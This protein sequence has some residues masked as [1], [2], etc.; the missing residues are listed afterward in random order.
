MQYTIS[1]IIPMLNE[2]AHIGR[3]LDYLIRDNTQVNIKEIIIVDGGSDDGSREIV[4]GFPKVILLTS[5]AGRARQ[6][7][8]GARKAAGTILYFL[9]AD[10]YPPQGF[11]KK[12]IQ[13]VERGYTGC[14]RLRFDPAKHYLLR[15]GAWCTQF[16]GLWFR[17]GDQSLFIT[18]A[19]FDELAG[20]DE[21]YR[22]Y[23][24]VEFVRRI[25]S[26][27]PFK[28]ID[29]PVI[30]SARKFRANGTVRLYFHFLMIHLRKL[31]G[32][33]PEQLYRYYEQHIR[34]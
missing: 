5:G 23:E 13:E 34:S 18:K 28:I 21:R 22:I 24:D 14:F 26:R 29:D 6:L 12:I 7:N 1:I 25:L 16:H 30:T 8:C 27:Y 2:A 10:T 9:H 19:Q 4:A 17:G 32:A 20:F 11:A 33:S 15:F 3:L 31:L